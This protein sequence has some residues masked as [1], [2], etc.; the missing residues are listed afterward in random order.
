MR[1]GDPNDELLS[2]ARAGGRRRPCCDQCKRG[3]AAEAFHSFLPVSLSVKPH[4]VTRFLYHCNFPCDKSIET[5]SCRS[6]SRVSPRPCEN[7]AINR[8]GFHGLAP[9]GLEIRR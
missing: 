7:T 2:G 3:N 8:V 4:S 9:S 1:V 5:A 6:L